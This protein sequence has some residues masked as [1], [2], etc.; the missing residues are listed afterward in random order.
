MKKRFVIYGVLGFVLLAFAFF[1]YGVGRGVTLLNYQ[2]VTP[3]MTMEEV[4]DVLGE[5]NNPAPWP[6]GQPIRV[7]NQ[8]CAQHCRGYGGT[9]IVFYDTNARVVAKEWDWSNRKNGAL[10]EFVD[11]VLRLF[12][13]EQKIRE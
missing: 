6:Y 10:D 1:R 3:G 2:Y 8:G 13:R 5:S 9:I 4:N 12:E 7:P 11:D